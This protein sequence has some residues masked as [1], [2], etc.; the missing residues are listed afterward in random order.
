MIF[1]TPTHSSPLADG[2]A[3]RAGSSPVKRGQLQVS[4]HRRERG[5]NL[6]CKLRGKLPERRQSLFVA[7]LSLH[8]KQD[9]VE[10]LKRFVFALQVARR[11]HDVV[12]ESCVS[13]R[14][15]LRRLWPVD[16]ASR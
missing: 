7:Q 2:H 3:A 6:V 14:E 15:S 11:G 10:R 13:D 4:R 12:G 9:L 16:R 8:L 1:E 5:S